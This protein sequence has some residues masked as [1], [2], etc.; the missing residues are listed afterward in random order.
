VQSAWE[1]LPRHYANVELD[2]FVVMPNHVHGI[3]IIRANGIAEANPVGAGHMGGF[4]GAVH[5]PPLPANVEDR[6]DQVGGDPQ[7]QRRMLLPR[8]IG[9]LKMTTAKAIN[10]SRGTPGAMVWQRSFYEHI[11]RDESRLLRIREYLLANPARWANDPENAS[12]FDR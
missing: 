2:A 9:R 1:D 3:V 10:R 8:V 12:V 6:N 4:V 5:E 11:V 7:R